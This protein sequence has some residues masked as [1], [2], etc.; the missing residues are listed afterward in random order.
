MREIPL[1]VKIELRFLLRIGRVRQAVLTF[2]YR[3]FLGR[4]RLTFFEGWRDLR[5]KPLRAADFL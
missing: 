3:A 2:Y 4:D 1:D 5:G